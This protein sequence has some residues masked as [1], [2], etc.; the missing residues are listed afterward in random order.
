MVSPDIMTI[1]ECRTAILQLV[2][3]GPNPAS[4]RRLLHVSRLKLG[5]AI[6]RV[7]NGELTVETM[8]EVL[9]HAECIAFEVD[10]LLTAFQRDPPE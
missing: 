3:R 4:I 7:E 10:T 9:R 6:E 5:A 8:G 2:D 1:D